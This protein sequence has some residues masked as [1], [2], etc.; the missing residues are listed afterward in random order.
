[1]R[2]TVTPSE[3]KYSDS[4]DSRKTFIILMFWLVLYML[5]NIFF[6]L[7]LYLSILLALWNLT[8]LWSFFFFFFPPSITFFIVVINLCLYIGLLWFCGSFLSFFLSFIFFFLF[9]FLNFNFEFF[10]P[11]IIS[12]FIPLFYFPTVPFHLQL[13]FNVYKSSLSTSIYLCISIHSFFPLSPFLS[14]YL[15]VLFSLLYSPV[16]NLF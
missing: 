12:S 8:K 13:I 6:S 16:G 11:I 2:W 10:K 15:L 14:T 9:S 1:M 3:G 4:S 7:P 5:L